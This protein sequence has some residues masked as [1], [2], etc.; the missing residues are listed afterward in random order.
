VGDHANRM[1]NGCAHAPSL[2]APSS[3]PSPSS[4]LSPLSSFPSPLSLSPSSRPSRRVPVV[5]RPRLGVPVTS[6]F[7]AP[8]CPS[9]SP[10][11]FVSSSSRCLVAPLSRLPRCPVVVVL[12]VPVRVILPV[13]IVVPCRVIV[14]AS[15]HV[16]LA[17]SPRPRLVLVA[18][19]CCQF[20]VSWF[21]G[22]VVSSLW[23][24]GF[25]TSPRRLALSR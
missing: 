12:P 6:V 10:R 1:K 16:F 23:H 14:G 8:S 5:S 13:C 18:V 7:V 11:H 20:V 19:S 15:S 3:Y 25:A 9:S 22:V 24:R 21:R 2:Q 4:S 17:W